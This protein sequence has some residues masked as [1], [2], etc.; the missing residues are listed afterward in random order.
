MKSSKARKEWIQK[1]REY[2]YLIRVGWNLGSIL[3]EEKLKG[4]LQLNSWASQNTGHLK[5]NRL[6]KLK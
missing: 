5:A 3:H 1:K 2:S 6:A 4:R